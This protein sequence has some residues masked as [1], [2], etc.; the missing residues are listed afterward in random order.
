MHYAVANMPGAVPRTASR[1]L[2]ALTLPYILKIAN[3]G[4]ER[5]L[6]QDPPLWRGVNT[7]QGQITHQG[8]AQSL[9]REWAALETLLPKGD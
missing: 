2:S 7:Y 1:A 8:V 9:G 5:A 6:R 4:C 3:E